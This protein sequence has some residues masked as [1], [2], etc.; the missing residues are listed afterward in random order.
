MKQYSTFLLA[1]SLS[2]MMLR[3]QDKTAVRPEFAVCQICKKCECG[4]HHR[5]ID[6]QDRLNS[7]RIR[8]A[9]PI[10]NGR[11]VPLNTGLLF[12][13]GKM[14]PLIGI[15]KTVDETPPDVSSS[16]TV[17]ESPKQAMDRSDSSSFNV[18]IP[19]LESGTDNQ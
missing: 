7:L 18:R 5:P 15:M 11:I 16:I 14:K 1:L 19:G 8:L 13:G 3:A 6:D 2:S 12:N 4:C 10:W 9:N 17:E